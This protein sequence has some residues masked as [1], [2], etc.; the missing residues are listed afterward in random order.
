MRITHLELVEANEVVEQYHRHNKPV[1]GH[2]FSI[3]AL[4]EEGILIGAAI[5]GRPIA[6]AL[7]QT[8]TVEILRVATNGD[9]NVN[10][11]LYGAAIRAA[12]ALGYTSV[13]TYTLEKESQSTMKALGAKCEGLIVPHEWDCPSRRRKSQPVYK[14]QRY[15]WRLM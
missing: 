11:F 4:N 12:K 8:M 7:D 3:G 2:R 10:S 14:E 13:I 6:R 9:K 15:R 5:V 1:T